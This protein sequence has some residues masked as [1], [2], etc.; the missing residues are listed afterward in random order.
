MRHEPDAEFRLLLSS[1]APAAP[2]RLAAPGHCPD[3]VLDEAVRSTSSEC[4]AEDLRDD[5]DAALAE[6]F[7][8]LRVQRAAAARR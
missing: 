3:I 7:L 5:S 2:A 1:V 4:F 6:L 8:M